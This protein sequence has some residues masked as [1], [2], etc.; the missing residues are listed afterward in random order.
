MIEMKDKDLILQ[1]RDFLESTLGMYIIQTLTNEAAALTRQGYD[2]SNP[3]PL[4]AHDKASG[5]ISALEII[6]APLLNTD[7]AAGQ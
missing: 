5:V 3:S 6:K 7:M 2:H 4:R 1:T